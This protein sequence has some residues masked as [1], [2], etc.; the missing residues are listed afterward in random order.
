[1]FSVRCGIAAVVVLLGVA[2]AQTVPTAERDPNFVSAGRDGVVTWTV[3]AVGIPFVHS[4]RYGD[5]TYIGFDKAGN[6]YLR[7]SGRRRP[8]WSYHNGRAQELWE[9][10]PNLMR[11]TAPVG[12]PSAAEVNQQNAKAYSAAELAS[13]NGTVQFTPRP[14]GDEF[15]PN[16]YGAG[17]SRLFYWGGLDEGRPKIYS[18]TWGLMTYLGFDRATGISYLE[19]PV[20]IKATIAYLAG[21]K[22]NPGLGVA[23]APAGLSQPPSKKLRLDAAAAAQLAQWQKSA[24][25]NKDP[26]FWGEGVDRQFEWTE[27]AELGPRIMHMTGGAAY[28]VGFD[29]T[30]GMTYLSLGSSSVNYLTYKA[31]NG[32]PIPVEGLPAHLMNVPANHAASLK[33]VTATTIPAGGKVDNGMRTAN[34]IAHTGNNWT[35]TFIDETGAKQTLPMTRPNLVGFTPAMWEDANK[36]HMGLG[37]WLAA[38]PDGKLRIVVV[39]V[40]TNSVPGF[41]GNV[42]VAPPAT[43]DE[44]VTFA[45]TKGIVFAK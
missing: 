38:V 16:F 37:M 11:P 23:S 39:E 8:I 15:D 26:N 41:V 36:N 3:N 45:A 5:F 9:A 40:N 12:G 27:G 14:A 42:T 20:P 7:T 28:Y 2:Q 6:S 22:D 24:G 18:T 29:E 44:T 1:M 19:A 31:G 4:F 25:P 43:M 13:F 10:P 32:R 33:G 17:E 35:V 21:R 34:T 30:T